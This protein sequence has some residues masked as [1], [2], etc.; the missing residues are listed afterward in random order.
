MCQLDVVIEEEEQRWRYTCLEGVTDLGCVAASMS[1]SVR[2]SR[3]KKD[4]DIKCNWKA[5]G[6]ERRGRNKAM[7]LQR[8]L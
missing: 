6:V 1:T 2:L 8:S 7:Q 5:D 4:V 3:L